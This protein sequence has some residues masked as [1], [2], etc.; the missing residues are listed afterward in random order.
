MSSVGVSPRREKI[1]D[2]RQRPDL[3]DAAKAR[4]FD[5][6]I[7]IA[8]WAR[9]HGVPAALVYS[10]LRGERRCTRGECHKIAVALGLKHDPQNAAP[11][12]QKH[13]LNAGAQ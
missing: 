9:E 3:L 11:R 5:H 1:S 10:I 8:Q 2:V 13:H 6:G 4:F 12:R 7:S